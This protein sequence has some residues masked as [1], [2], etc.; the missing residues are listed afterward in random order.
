M[1]DDG[2]LDGISHILHVASVQATHVDAAILQQ[3]DVVLAGQK[4]N[5][6]SCKENTTLIN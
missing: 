2:I 5:L 4:L 3:V 6:N 1:S